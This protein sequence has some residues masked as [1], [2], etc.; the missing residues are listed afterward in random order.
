[1]WE[2]DALQASQPITHFAQPLLLVFEASWLVAGGVDPRGLSLWTRKN[3]A[4]EWQME[5]LWY[6]EGGHVLLAWL[7]SFHCSYARGSGN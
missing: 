3:A 4:D 7:I 5:E 6:D 2:L 1:M